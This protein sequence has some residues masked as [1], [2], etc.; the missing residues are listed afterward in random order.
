[1]KAIKMFQATIVFAAFL[2]I[3]G[4]S[5]EIM[6]PVVPD[7]KT[8]SGQVNEINLQNEKESTYDSFRTKISLK[9][10]Q[11]HSFDFSN[12]GFYNFSQILLTTC[13]DIEVIGYNDDELIW[14]NCSSTGFYARS[15]TVR[16]LSKDLVNPEVILKGSTK[17]SPDPLK[18]KSQN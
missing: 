4:C 3:G 11:T 14:L 16:N 18:I 5:D 6:S 17:K 9:P 7:S 1:M 13:S 12:T 10:G 15:I 8:V 2:I